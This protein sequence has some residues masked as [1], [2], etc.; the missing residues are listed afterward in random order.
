MLLN[1]LTIGAIAKNEGKYL[2]EWLAFHFAVGADRII[3]FSNE[4]EDDQILLLRKIAAREPR[5][6]VIDWASP[7]NESPQISAY[8][9]AMRMISTDWVSFIDIDEFIVPMEHTSITN[10]LMTVP[11][12]V[13]SIHINWR[14][15]GS[16]GIAEANYDL[17]TRT[18]LEGA[19]LGWGN[20]HHFKS[21]ARTNMVED[22]GIHNISTSFGR[23][24][25][26]DFGEFETVN[27]GLSNRIIHKPLRIQHYQCKT[28]SEFNSRMKRGDAN[29]P[30]EHPG[31]S[32]DGSLERFQQIDLNEVRD[33]SIRRF[34][35]PV[36]MQLK[37]LRHL[38]SS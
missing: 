16:S 35:L 19:A 17:V 2:V 1:T 21:L 28:F 8:R 33:D 4:S 22:V 7:H 5:L 30:P 13:S 32:R 3:I 27:D 11:S 24:T 29:F 25:L 37:R 10:Y 23:R 34:D 6:T 31:R 15:F 9:H 20:H 38:L 12:D 26:S 18:F 36:D 14:N